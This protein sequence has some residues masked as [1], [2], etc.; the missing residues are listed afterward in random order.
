MEKDKKRRNHW[1]TFCK[2]NARD[3]LLIDISVQYI[4]EIM[5]TNPFHSPNYK[6]A[7]DN[8]L[9]SHILNGHKSAL[10]SLVKRHQAYIFNVALKLINNKSDAED[11]TQEV[12]IKVIS[13]LSSFDPQKAKFR[14]WLYR[15]TFNHILNLK[16]QKY[17]HLVSGFD[18]FFDY[19]DNT[20]DTLMEDQ[21]EKA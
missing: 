15:I 2:F 6:D 21:G 11:V 18:F 4:G 14:T 7:A 17:E 13:K 20:P 1:M 9:I 12:L 3:Y 10:E 8:E 16:K 19:I 5:H